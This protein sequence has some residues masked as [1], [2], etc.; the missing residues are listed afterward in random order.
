MN[1]PK[2]AECSPAYS[3]SVLV[4]VYNEERTIGEI[5]NRLRDG[6]YPD[7]Q[8][9]VVNDGSTDNTR[10]LLDQWV[11][12]PGFIVIHHQANRG[13][14]A[15]IRTALSSASGMFTVIQDADLEYDPMDLPLLVEALRCGNCQVIYGSRYLDT[16]RSLKWN[17]FRLAVAGINF[18]VRLLYGQSLS[19]EATGYKAFRTDLLKRLELRAKRFELCAEI[20][21]KVCRLGIRINEVPVSYRP[22]SVAEGKKIGWRDIW[23][24][25]WTLVKWR[26]LVFPIND[27]RQTNAKELTRTE[28]TG[29]TINGAAE[30]SFAAMK[31]E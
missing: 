23:P 22:R 8:V 11:K 12:V 6:P 28:F 3:L 20:S 14:G 4:P 19:D 27:N 30:E 25:I 21:A 15:A 31:G 1:M 2:N 16:N 10:N 17:R 9:I 26:F 29:A 18:L 24:T 13:K 5:L 7:K